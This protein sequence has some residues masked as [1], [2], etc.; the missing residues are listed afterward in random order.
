MADKCRCVIGIDGGASSTGA[1]LMDQ[2]LTVIAEG[3]GGPA[4]HY[5]AEDGKE[6]L[7]KSLAKAVSPLLTAL[8]ASPRLSLE[9]V[10][11]GLTGVTIPGK[12]QAAMEILSGLFP[13][14]DVIIES[15]TVTAWAGALSGQD[16]VIVIGGTGSVAFG[17]S[18]ARETRKGGFGYLFGDEGSGF[19]IACDA[20]S[21][22][23]RE[24][25]GTGPVT[26]LSIA[27]RNFFG[28]PNVRMVPGKVYSES[29]PVEQIAALCP[30]VVAQAERGD[31][32]AHRIVVEAGQSLGRLAVAALE[33]FDGEVHKV[34][35]AG[36][37]FQAGEAIL[38]PFRKEIAKALPRAEVLAPAHPPLIGAGV[39]AWASRS[40]R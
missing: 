7:G 22:T 29:I 6:R 23:L 33:A 24:Y 4:D 13:G 15:D 12:N 35:Y 2:N 14:A 11:L 3:H 1:A 34:S 20:I 26:S 16:G 40:R 9:A 21:A 30:L 38:R 32:V 39:M 37:V 5:S 36:G 28:V 18:G 25:D 17:R 31:E 27:V 10:C 19:R 8:S